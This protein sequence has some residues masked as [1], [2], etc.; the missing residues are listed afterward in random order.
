[1]LKKKERNCI[2]AWYRDKW[3]SEKQRGLTPDHPQIVWGF[4]RLQ[5]CS[6]SAAME[7]FIRQMVKA[8]LSV[9]MK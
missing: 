7:A 6:Y 2:S 8:E 4:Q 1:M 5:R 3:V 9:H